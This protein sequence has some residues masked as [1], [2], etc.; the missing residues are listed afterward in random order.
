[1]R[2]L[3][4]FVRVFFRHFYTTLAWS[5]DLVAWTVSIGQ[6]N[7]WVLAVLEPYPENPMLEIAHG[8]GHLQ[9]ATNLRGGEIFGVDASRQMGRMASRRLKRSGYSANLVQARAQ[10]LPFPADAFPTLISTFPTE[11]ILEAAS[12]QEA[13]RTLAPGGEY[14]VVAMAEIQGDGLLERLAAW[15]FRIT[16]QYAEI[17]SSWMDPIYE[18][19][20]ELRRDD[21]QLARSRV[22]RYIV[23]EAAQPENEVV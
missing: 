8:P 9:L 7:S 15:L 17:P 19:G 1:M 11:F 21:V 14:R 10:A 16:G 2:F 12:L 23:R 20:F 13:R 18:A 5:Y 6:W 4:W 22:I 3:H